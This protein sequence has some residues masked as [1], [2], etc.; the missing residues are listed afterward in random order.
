MLDDLK[1]IFDVDEKTGEMSYC[2]PFKSEWF[3]ANAASL[4][5]NLQLN[6]DQMN[7][8]GS[9]ELI[10]FNDDSVSQLAH[11]IDEKPAFRRYY[12]RLDRSDKF[13]VCRISVNHDCAMNEM[14]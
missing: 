12:E 9:L 11:A 3:S 7:R 14:T 4:N 10:E 8:L 13:I 1:N 6:E 2:A 5:D